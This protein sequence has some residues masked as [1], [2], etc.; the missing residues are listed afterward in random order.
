MEKTPKE[1][2]QCY[3]VGESPQKPKELIDL[4]IESENSKLLNDKMTVK[5]F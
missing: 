2:I 4:E 5:I 1:S 3:S